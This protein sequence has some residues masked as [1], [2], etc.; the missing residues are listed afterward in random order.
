MQNSVVHIVHR[1]EFLTLIRKQQI[2]LDLI[3]CMN[4]VT[5]EVVWTADTCLGVSS[6][7]SRTVDSDGELSLYESVQHVLGDPL[8][9]RI[10]M[11][12]GKC[13]K[14]LHQRPIL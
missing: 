10:F 13:V 14:M 1:H 5:E 12:E 4:Q 11:V 7:E 8:A 6:D 3:A 9:L 2:A